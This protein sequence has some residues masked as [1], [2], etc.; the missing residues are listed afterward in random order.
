MTEKGVATAHYEKFIAK[1][2]Q[3]N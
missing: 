1:L 2:F 3:A